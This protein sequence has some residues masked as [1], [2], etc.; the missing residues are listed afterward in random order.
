MDQIDKKIIE[1]LRDRHGTPFYVMSPSRYR[2]NLR[3]FLSAF[4]AGY[5]KV[6]VG[7]S[8]KTNYVP[9]LCQIAK[10]E[11]CYAE[12]VSEMELELALK[13]GFTHIIFNG[14]IKRKRIIEKAIACK[15]IINL[16]SEYEIDYICQYK[17]DHPETPLSIGLRLNVQL[18]D[19]NGHSTVQ[20]GLRHGRFGFPLG[21]LD[22]NINRLRKAGITINSVHGHTSSSD[23][24]VLNYKIITEYMLYVCKEFNL[25]DVEYFDI[26]GGF[27]GAPPEGLDVSSK[28]SYVDYAQ[29]VLDLVIKNNWFKRVKPFIVIEPGSSVVSNVF[30]YYTSVYQLKSIGSKQFVIVDGTVFDVKPT[31]HTSNLPFSV[32]N[33]SD[34]L[35]TGSDDDHMV[36]DV[37]G[38]TCM[39]KDIILRDVKIPCLKKADMI[40]IRGVGS[41]TIVLSP[42]F[43]NYLAPIFSIE[44]N[45]VKTI[46]R[47]QSIEDVLNLYLL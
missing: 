14:P 23:R 26:G 9:A 42:T 38:S 35:V 45:K 47:R 2:H 12:V 32:I 8:F 27:F 19:D 5:D 17:I 7:Y 39:E 33:E 43:I 1:G 34:P 18:H 29:M 22:K 3:S 13:L 16:D 11:G 40:Q 36:C 37:V 6:I 31:M 24:A 10:E 15:A 44:N 20:C 21:I 30:D 4:T 28:P 46:R 25:S 41:Y